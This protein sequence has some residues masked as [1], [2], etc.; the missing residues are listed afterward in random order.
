MVDHQQVGVLG[1]GARPL[2][3]T[4]AAAVTHAVVGRAGRGI[5]GNALPHGIFGCAAQVD[6]RAVAAA[7]SVQPH[8]HL[9]EHPCLFGR[10]LTLVE[11]RVQAVGAKVVGAPFQ[12]GGLQGLA[13]HFLHQRNVFLNELVL[14]V[15]G[16]GRDDHAGVVL[17]REGRRRQQVGQRLAGAGAGFHNQVASA[18]EGFADGLS[19]LHLVLPVL[20]L[21]KALLQR[22]AR[23]QQRRHRAGIQPPLG[24]GFASAGGDLERFGLP[25]GR[26]VFGRAFPRAGAAHQHLLERPCTQPGGIHPHFD[27][28]G[29]QRQRQVVDH[30]GQAQVKVRVDTGVV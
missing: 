27:D 6:F 8:Q 21:G 24:G 25:Q 30:F 1:R 15:F 7:A 29:E 13:Q 18:V 2:E 14:Q 5:G 12:H 3:R 11:Q 9:G 10:F 4:L 23:F 28:V 26:C 22:A 17:P 19:H 20:K 16:V